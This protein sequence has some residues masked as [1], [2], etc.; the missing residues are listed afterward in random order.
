MGA[1]RTGRLP[2]LKESQVILSTIRTS[3]KH[4]R[5]YL[6]IEHKSKPDSYLYL[7]GVLIHFGKAA[8]VLNVF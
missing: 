1:I 4:A 2:E 3:E 8:T 7:L 6:D 5:S